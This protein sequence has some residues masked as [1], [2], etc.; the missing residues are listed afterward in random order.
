MLLSQ[1]RL[2]GGLKM[3]TKHTAETLKYYLGREVYI[4]RGVA[5]HAAT[6]IRISSKSEMVKVEW[7]AHNG[8]N[9]T[10][11]DISKESIK[12]SQCYPILKTAEE[13][14]EE[15]FNQVYINH[16]NIDYMFL[17]ND[18]EIELLN[19][20]EC[21]GEVVRPQA[22]EIEKLIN[23]GYGA[24]PNEESPTGYVDLFGNPCVTPKQVEE[25]INL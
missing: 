15:E 6:L 25:G 24:I 16:S 13:L 19:C 8:N 21:L 11:E 5:R 1:P 2:L 9:F 17:E 14:T 7:E 23:L 18:F 3:K 12:A 4:D 20:N 22:Y 10:E